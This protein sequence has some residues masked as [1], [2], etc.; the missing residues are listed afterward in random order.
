M[1]KLPP[2]LLRRT[3][4]LRDFRSRDGKYPPKRLHVRVRKLHAIL[5]RIQDECGGRAI[6]MTSTWRS[7]AHNKRVRGTKRSQHLAARAVDFKIAGMSSASTHRFV[8]ALIAHRRI[9]QGGVGRYPTFVHYDF[10]G[11]AA[12]WSAKRDKPDQNL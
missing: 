1:N 4:R 3:F 5:L 11:R 12:R 8:L 2:V 10:R 9:P 6:T 7:P